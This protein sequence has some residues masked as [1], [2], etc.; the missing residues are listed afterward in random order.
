[1]KKNVLIIGANSKIAYEL[2]KILALNNYNLFL[3]SK[4]YLELKKKINYLKN[5]SK[6]KIEF[7][8]FDITHSFS[9]NEILKKFSK[10]EILILASGFLDVKNRNN[11]KTTEINYTG[12]KN[13][14]EKLLITNNNFEEIICFTSVSG[15]RVDANYNEY[16]NSKKRLSE[17]I[18]KNKSRFKKKNIYLKDLKLGYVN[19]NMT[20]HIFLQNIVCSPPQKVA[21]YIYN[22]IALKNNNVIYYPK[23]WIQ[24]L[25]IYNFVKR[26]QLMFKYF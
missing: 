9:F 4:N 8:K 22:N 19:T 17:F 23:I 3:L 5:I 25:K 1:M 24:I 16:S 10:A 11:I 2:S 21:R 26:I 18:L 15:D 14:I 12:P 7:Y 13:F 20:N 6:S